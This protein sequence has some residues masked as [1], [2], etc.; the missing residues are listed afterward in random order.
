MR[1]KISNICDIF[2]FNV[3]LH[4]TC[5]VENIRVTMLGKTMKLGLFILF[6]SKA[7]LF[8]LRQRTHP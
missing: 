3:E 7:G 8:I 6:Y 1:E 2:L 5:Q 4:P